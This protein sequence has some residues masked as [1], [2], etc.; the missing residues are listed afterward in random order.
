MSKK[1]KVKFNEDSVG[2]RLT[3]NDEIEKLLGAAY[4]DYQMQG[5]YYVRSEVTRYVKSFKKEFK[6]GKII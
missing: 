1:N 3:L 2:L 4:G 5:L 6:T